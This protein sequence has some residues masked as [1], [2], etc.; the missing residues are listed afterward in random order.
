MT[1]SEQI[2]NY[3]EEGKSIS[4]I[5]KILNVNYSF[6][7]QVAQR[8]CMKNNKDFKTN[9]ADKETKSDVIRKLWN[10]GKT[11]GEISHILNTNYTY[12]W[13]IVNKL[14]NSSNS[15]K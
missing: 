12:C 1:K 14:R 11:I 4:E 5:A 2:R 15:E 13:N 7:Y 8:H 9:R 6:V 3:F 10:Q